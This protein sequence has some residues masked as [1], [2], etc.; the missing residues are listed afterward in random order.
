MPVYLTVGPAR[1][2]PLIF[3]FWLSSQQFCHALGDSAI[4]AYLA[5]GNLRGPPL[6]AFAKV[7]VSPKPAE[8]RNCNIL[9]ESVGCRW[10]I[11]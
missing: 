4:V 5:V 1:K 6:S 3:P 10:R 7:Q 2:T 8:A 11:I 9:G